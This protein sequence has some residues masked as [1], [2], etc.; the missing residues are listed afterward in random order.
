[1]S[2]FSLSTITLRRRILILIAGVTLP[3]VPHVFCEAPGHDTGYALLLAFFS[4]I[5][6][7]AILRYLSSPH[8]VNGVRWPE[9]LIPDRWTSIV[10]ADI[11]IYMICVGFDTEY[12]YRTAACHAAPIA[13]LLLAVIL[14]Y[15]HGRKKARQDR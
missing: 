11:T 4:L 9:T 12:G 10:L 7:L 1:M 6:T 5:G 2:R 3:S 8:W 14:E 15:I 13:V